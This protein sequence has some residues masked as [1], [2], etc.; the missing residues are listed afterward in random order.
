[1]VSFDRID[2]LIFGKDGFDKNPNHP[3][4]NEYWATKINELRQNIN[5]SEFWE[6]S[7]EDE[8]F[9]SFT[10]V[11]PINKLLYF[12]TDYKIREVLYGDR[13]TFYQ[14][15]IKYSC[16][17]LINETSE[18]I[19]RGD[20][21]SITEIIFKIR[22]YIFETNKLSYKYYTPFSFLLNYEPADTLDEEIRAANFLI[23]IYF[24]D[25]LINL[26]Y[27]LRLIGDSSTVD[28]NSDQFIVRSIEDKIY[29][30]SGYGLFRFH[31]NKSLK[32]GSTDNLHEIYRRLKSLYYSTYSNSKVNTILD[33]DLIKDIK[34]AENELF[35]RIVLPQFFDKDVVSTFNASQDDLFLISYREFQS[36]IS[37]SVLPNERLFL[38]Q[39]IIKSI[40]DLLDDDLNKNNLFEES[41]PRKLIRKLTLDY[42]TIKANPEIDLKEFDRNTI[43]PIQTNISVSQ[44]ALLFKLLEEKSIIKTEQRSDLYKT[45][46]KAFLSKSVT[47]NSISEKSFQ[48]N[49]NDPDKGAYKYWTPKFEAFYKECQ[50]IK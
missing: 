44:L 5:R 15:D 7:V 1:M 34:T 29:N 3:K 20:I 12:V 24:R 28:F 30:S 39:N 50:K 43:K 27:Q 32:E 23:N 16:F 37:A 18:L 14:S 26:W 4:E 2:S 36:L 31:V 22:W 47:G 40:N 13:N 48:N 33:N 6:F 9:Q 46:T 8:L 10:K 17:K 11:S 49:F 45:I 25:C 19:R 41:A 21:S 35:V 42:E 38:I